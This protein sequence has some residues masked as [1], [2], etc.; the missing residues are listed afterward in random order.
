MKLTRV[1]NLAWQFALI[2][3][4]VARATLLPAAGSAERWNG[5]HFSVDAKALYARASQASHTEGADVS[6]LVDEA[7]YDFDA[8]GGSVRAYYSVFKVLSAKGAEDWAQ[9]TVGWEPWNG[10]RPTIRARVIAADYSV[11]ELDQKTIT[12]APAGD[13]SSN[14][15]SDRR[16]VRVP[17]PAIA[18]GAVV[19]QE[20][21]LKGRALFP[22]AGSM[23]ATTFGRVSAPVE[24][25]RLVVKA[26][27][28]LPFRYHMWLLPD[29]KPQRTESN[30]KVTFVFESGPTAALGEPDSYL[31]SDVPAL[32]FVEFSTGA[33]W[34]QI[35]EEYAK[36]VDAHV[37]PS[38]VSGLV[39][40]LT[41]DKRS[42]AEKLQAITGYLDSEIR[43]TGIEFGDSTIIPHS[44]AETLTRKYGDCKD[45]ASLL[46]VML[47]AAGVPAYVALL[48]SGSGLDVTTELPS[49]TQFD[50]AIV[51]VPG[52][53]ELWID[54]TDE[55][56]RVG[57]IP[58]DDQGRLALIVRP[59]SESLVR[60]PQAPSSANVRLERRE[61][62]LGDYGPARVVETSQPKGSFESEYRHIFADR[63]SKNTHDNLAS[64]MK[65]QYLAA[66][67]DS[68]DRTDP[69]DLSKPF[70]LVVQSAKAERGF[71]DLD[72]AVVAI[73][74]TSLFIDLPDELKTHA[75]SDDRN[76]DKLTKKRM[77]DYQ[78][79]KA[80]TVDWQYKII[81]PTGFEPEPLPK[82]FT[83][84]L[85]PTQL[86]GHFAAD[87]TGA[88]SVEIRF[89]TTKR[90]FSVAEADEMCEKIATVS[91]GEATLVKFQPAAKS[92]MMQGKARE[93]F[94]SYRG[95][96]AHNPK[97]AIDHLRL[98][99]AL[100]NA[101]FGGAAREEARLAVKLEPD[102]A[103]AEKS[104]AYILESDEVGRKFRPG[105]DLSAAAAAFR[106][107]AKLDP[108]DKATIGD[109]AILLEYNQNG[110]RYGRG[111][112]QREA[113]ETYRKLT[114]EER[115]RVGLPANLAYALFYVEDFAEARK[116]AES[117]NPQPKDLIIACEAAMNGSQSAITAANSLGSDADDYRRLLRSAG[118]MLLTSRKYPLAADLIQAGA[119][120][121]DAAGALGV[122]TVLREAQLH[123]NVAPA[124]T[125]EAVAL[126]NYMSFFDSTALD[127]LDG[128]GSKNLAKLQA[129][130]PGWVLDSNRDNRRRQI[131][132]TIL[133]RDLSDVTIDMVM[134]A[135]VQKEGND[136]SGYHIKVQAAGWRTLT[137][138]VVKEGGRYRLLDTS[139]YPNVVA[140]EVLDRIKSND[141]EGARALLDW[142]R[143][144][145]HIGGGD[146]PLAGNPFPRLWTKGQTADAARMKAA[147]AAVLVQYRPTAAMGL[148][149]IEEAITASSNEADKTSLRIAAVLGYKNTGDYSKELGVASDLAKQ[150]PESGFAFGSAD[151]ALR[152]SG[153]FDQ[154][155]DL[156]EQRLKRLPEDADSI[157]SEFWTYVER[158]DHRAAYQR[159]AL[160]SDNGKATADD[161]NN[162]AWESLFFARAGGP[163][164]DAAIRATQMKQNDYHS[165][166]TLACLYAAAGKTSE[167]RQVLLQA[168]DLAGLNVPDADYWYAFGRLAE[169]AGE[170]ELALA[171]YARVTKPNEPLD[172]PNS[173]Y[174]LAQIKLKELQSPPAASAT[175]ANK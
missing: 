19:E 169:A 161:L 139:E 94:E 154:A 63:Q 128:L 124:N 57:E 44:A 126:T 155:I 168:M 127:A 8:D 68:W 77:A 130:I 141:L 79:P 4:F 21:V 150:Y 38:D 42:P 61:I 12:D 157:R 106:T 7:T 13:Q 20:F 54:A 30:G 67:L 149:I 152:A 175:T 58:V 72:S 137:A 17:L 37:S 83:L 73:P 59:G 172:V 115:A 26:P 82:D 52:P 87:A 164:V 163:D 99:N 84:A 85:G 113:V 24:H 46:A 170:R 159:L 136:A 90:R 95:M 171:D 117:L 65:T 86:S 92:L 111:A 51:Y 162:M 140:I 76:G 53:P 144:D 47:R 109:L 116:A 160:L 148:P 55:R 1:W 97:Q 153:R 93:A 78:L 3:V 35:A 39:E 122:A 9:A 22:G 166:H 105:S 45:K 142:L 135:K 49:I 100:L 71:T 64:Y 62:T 29:L 114:D 103:L 174:T 28:E 66:K 120:D 16:V 74:L 5:A 101:G 50:H 32:P 6:V 70:E 131:Y 27:P 165:L 25:T 15:F 112:N 10:E 156:A 129:T 132:R 110:E 102:S 43:Y 138:F 125:P 167:A 31:P 107:A 18:V 133:R 145:Y 104:L 75:S 2:G 134:Q 88:V 146:D 14:V 151:F 118:N 96:V 60:I 91:E 98:A 48:E 34:S 123:E 147:A 119:A 56:S 23:G 36:I 11:H 173:S 158:D 108:D 40:K 89:D 69:A 81:P 80:Y 143:D 41:K 121:S 33:S